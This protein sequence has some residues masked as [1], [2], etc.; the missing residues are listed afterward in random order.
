M[1]LPADD[2]LVASVARRVAN[3][4]VSVFAESKQFGEP[5]SSV[6]VS[7]CHAHWRP[8]LL[9]PT[10]WCGFESCSPK[11]AHRLRFHVGQ[12]VTKLAAVVD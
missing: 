11:Y 4:L 3:P 8:H 1:H 6:S 12:S 10:S 9:S 7:I 2:S 5:F